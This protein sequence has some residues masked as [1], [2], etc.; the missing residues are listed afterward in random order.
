M[1]LPLIWAFVLFLVCA[2][3]SVAGCRLAV[4]CERIGQAWGFTGSRAGLVMIGPFYRLQSQGPRTVSWVSNALAA[5]PL[6]NTGI[7]FLIWRM[8][9]R[10]SPRPMR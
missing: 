1:D 8:N 5:A 7:V 2:A 3:L 6:L 9:L 4:E 10:P